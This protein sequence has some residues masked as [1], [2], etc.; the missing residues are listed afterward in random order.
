MGG[1]GWKV[2]AGGG[3]V[4]VGDCGMG[5]AGDVG[6]MDSHTLV[7]PLEL[8]IWTPWGPLPEDLTPMGGGL[9]PLC[10]PQNCRME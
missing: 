7:W 8:G 5:G 3:R 9:S 4:C 1:R 2:G 6:D 10:G